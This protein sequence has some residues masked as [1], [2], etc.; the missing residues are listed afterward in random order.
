MG[1][2]RLEI[3]LPEF[4]KELSI[5]I[6]VRR[7]GEVV[8]STSS[9]SMGSNN[10]KSLSNNEEN[11]KKNVI[12]EKSLVNNLGDEIVTKKGTPDEKPVGGAKKKSKGNL[13]D[14]DI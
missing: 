5:N 12:E 10:S 4:E 6:I 2:M 11:K 1:T 14:L 8:Y 13:M 7:D 3:D 9:P